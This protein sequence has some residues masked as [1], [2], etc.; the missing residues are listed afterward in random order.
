V[1]PDIL[2]SA[3]ALGGG[4]PVSAMMTRTHIAESLGFGSHAST[5]GGNPLACAVAGA[6]VEMV[7]TPEMRAGVLH[8]HRR[9]VDGLQ[10]I[11]DRYGLFAEIRGQ[12]LLLGCELAPAFKGRA[13]DFVNSALQRGLM[14]LIAGPDVIRM[15]PSLVI[16]EDDID[17]GL[18][19]LQ[20]A[21]EDILGG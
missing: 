16:P 5:F 4:F 20:S 17:Q 2:T 13:R 8:R 19:R 10:S 15:T 3:K 9:I 21:I 11:N 6:V 12:G 14:L 7:D 1:E 18:M